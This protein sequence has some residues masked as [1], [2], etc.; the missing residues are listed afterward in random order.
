MSELAAVEETPLPNPWPAILTILR[1]GQSR[2]RL[3]ER[4]GVNMTTLRE[5]ELGATPSLLQQHRLLALLTPEPLTEPVPPKRPGI[6]LVTLWAPK[7]PN[8]RTRCIAEG[9]LYDDGQIVLRFGSAPATHIAV[10]AHSGAVL[11][12]FPRHELQERIL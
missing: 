6:R 4:L 10:F 9:L 8:T 7:E 12:A 5:W 1:D 3:S 11:T 2:A